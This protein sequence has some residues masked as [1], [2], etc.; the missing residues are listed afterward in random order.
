MVPLA[1]GSQ[2]VG[3]VL[4]PAAYCGVVGF[5]PTHGRISAAGVVPLSWSQ[6]HV[7]VFGR[8]VE[9]A[10]LAL[11]SSL[12]PPRRS[13]ASAPVDDYLA[14]LGDPPAPRLGVLAPSSSARRRRWPRTWTGSRGGSRPRGRR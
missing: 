1:L 2:T 6:D 5:K 9:D 4:R 3:S 13:L 12:G 7:G 11:R 8:A 10:A 14:A